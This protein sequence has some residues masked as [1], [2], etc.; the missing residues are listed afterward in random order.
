MNDETHLGFFDI[1]LISNIPNIVCLAPTCKEEYFAMLEWSLRQDS[2][3]VAIRVPALGLTHADREIATDY[4]EL[5]RYEMVKKGTKVALFG[6]GVYNTIKG[7]TGSGAVNQRD[8]VTV[9]QGFENAG[10]DIVNADFVNQMHELWTANGGGTS[11]GWGFK[12]VNEPVYEQT[13][14]AADQIKAAADQT[15]TAIYVIARNSGEGSDRSSGKGDY[16]LSDDERANLELLGKTFDN[17]VVVLNVGG[18]IDTKFF[19]EIN[20]LDSMLLMSQAG[21]EGGNALADILTG[22]EREK[23]PQT[24]GAGT[25]KRD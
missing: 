12:W 16:L 18:I 19:S 20:G 2:H 15:D 22:T 4:S 10:Y 14:G 13:E 8:N 6:Q 1:P 5:N 17:V 9:Q 3:P 23:A 11:Q 25:R 24:G 21:M 7:G